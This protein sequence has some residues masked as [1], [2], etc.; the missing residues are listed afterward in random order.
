VHCAQPA[1]EAHENKDKPKEKIDEA[2]KKTSDTLISSNKAVEIVIGSG[3]C[4][5]VIGLD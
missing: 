4:Q 2:T 3:F 5:D 1:A